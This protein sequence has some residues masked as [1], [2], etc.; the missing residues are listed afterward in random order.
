MCIR[1]RIQGHTDA[2]GS[3]AANQRLSEK[4]AYAVVNFLVQYGGIDAKRL[5]AKGYGESQPVASNETDEGR[6][7][8]RRVDFVILK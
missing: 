1:D 4:R 8:N 6:Q 5:Q 3:D 7:L 2:I